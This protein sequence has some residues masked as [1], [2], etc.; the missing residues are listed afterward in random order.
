MN[1]VYEAISGPELVNVTERLNKA[2]ERLQPLL[3]K[4]LRIR[5]AREAMAKENGA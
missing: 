2:Q 5:R 1:A 3:E 4:E